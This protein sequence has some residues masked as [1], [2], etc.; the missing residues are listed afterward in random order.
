MSYPHRKMNS[1]GGSSSA[2]N[3][4]L[5]N[6]YLIWRKRVLA[7]YLVMVTLRKELYLLEKGKIKGYIFRSRVRWFAEGVKINIAIFEDLKTKTVSA[8]LEILNSTK[9]GQLLI[10]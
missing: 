2:M 9:T 3:L 8:V 5:P 7:M 10:L 4:Q 6:I 1:K